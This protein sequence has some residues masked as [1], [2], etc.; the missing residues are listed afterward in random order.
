MNTSENK[1]GFSLT[2]GEEWNVVMDNGNK[3]LAQAY[4]R[5]L[6]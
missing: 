1:T 6:D 3:D 5:S 4:P 2:A